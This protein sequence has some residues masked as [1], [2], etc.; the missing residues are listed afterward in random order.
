M[1]DS[2]GKAIYVLPLLDTVDIKS[3]SYINASISQS[4]YND[5][6][7]YNDLSVKTGIVV[8]TPSD[9]TI[10]VEFLLAGLIILLLAILS[11]GIYIFVQRK[12]VSSTKVTKSYYDQLMLISNIYALLVTT[13]S[14]LPI[15]NIIKTEQIENTEITILISGLSVG[16]DS[17]LQNFQQDFLKHLVQDSNSEANEETTSGIS[18]S[19]IDR[20][21]FKILIA[22][23]PSFRVFV[24][25]KE[26]TFTGTDN[27]FRTMITNL[28]TNLAVEDIIDDTI[29]APQVEKI[30]NIYF[31]IVFLKTFT[32][33]M[34]KFTALF[35]DNKA[36][37]ESILSLEALNALKSIFLVYFGQL[38]PEDLSSEKANKF[39][40]ELMHTGHL[41]AIGNFKY[42]ELLIFLEKQL[43]LSP[44]IIYELLW[45][46]G[47]YEVRL[48]IVGT[49]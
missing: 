27:L 1:T 43:K 5:A 7:T 44:K 47:L 42:E 39:F 18:I 45:T 48:F 37:K 34:P 30:A 19:T 31:P 15:F 33:N 40:D 41:P 49:H 4:T 17:F 32:I 2:N 13:A 28:E 11:Y 38:K 23:S 6:Y 20:E 29:I 35:S 14:G 36:N 25:L 24:F 10:Y 9:L 21:T 22:S 8:Q 12:Q 16:M 3:F 46:A 26:K